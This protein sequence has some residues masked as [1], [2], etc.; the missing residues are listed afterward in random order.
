MADTFEAWINPLQWIA[1]D[2]SGQKSGESP[3]ELSLLRFL[4]NPSEDHSLEMAIR[5]YA[6]INEAKERVFVAPNHQAFLQKLVWPLRSAKSSFVIGNFISTIAQCGMVAEM[7]TLLWSEISQ[8]TIN[9]S[10]L[11][12]REAS[13]LFGSAFE[14]LGQERRVNILR[15]FGVIDDEQFSHFDQVRLIR[16]R[17]LHF[18]SQS[19]DSI[20]DDSLT[21]FHSS[22]LLVARLMSIAFQDGRVSLRPAL[23]R[24]VEGRVTESSPS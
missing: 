21:A 23:M 5:R 15:A 24:Y 2:L 9:G 8:F 20:E 18:L 7:V 19:H 1:A 16:R 6:A 22:V 10:H 17:Y 3:D 11:T 4:A 14:R 13:Q 12:D